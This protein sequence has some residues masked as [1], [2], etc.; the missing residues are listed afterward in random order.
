MMVESVFQVFFSKTKNWT[1]FCLYLIIAIDEMSEDHKSGFISFI[2]QSIEHGRA[3]F[4][5]MKSD[6]GCPYILHLTLIK[7][8]EKEVSGDIREV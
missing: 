5:E 4:H 2:M 7:N 3:I 6:N 8:I 1:K